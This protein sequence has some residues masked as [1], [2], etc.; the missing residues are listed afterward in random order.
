[1]RTILL[2]V[3]IFYLTLVN[4]FGQSD[5]PKNLKQTVSYLDKD[6]SDSLKLIIKSTDDKEL[7]KL[8]YPFGNSQYKTIYYW[9]NN[10]KSGI[11]KY[12]TKKGIDNFKEEVILSNYKRH[13]NNTVVSEDSLLKPYLKIEAKWRVE[14]NNRFS[15]DTLRGVYIPKDLEDCFKQINIIWDENERNQILKWDENEFAGKAH[16]GFGMWMRNNWQLWKG[17]RLSRYFKDFKITHPDDMTGIILV[18]YYRFLSKKEIELQEQIKDVRDFWTNAEEQELNRIR[19]EFVKYKIGDVVEYY[20]NY[21]YVSEEQERNYDDGRCIAK[22]IIIERNDI[23][24]LLKI[25]VIEAC[26]KKGIIYYDN[27]GEMIYDPK[28]KKWNNPKKRI[29]KKMKVNQEQWFK[30][31]DWETIEDDL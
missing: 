11:Y 14:D 16:F 29:I 26:D 23:D 10:D 25:K 31:D 18:S 6:C 8:I 2:I 7:K 28:T 22:G 1:M 24:F 30:Y 27:E 20:F 19:E 5:M 4:S 15:T 12:L 17:S 13:L 9:S 21:G 3:S